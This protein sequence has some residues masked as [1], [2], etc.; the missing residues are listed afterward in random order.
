MIPNIAAERLKPS[1]HPVLFVTLTL[2]S[3]NPL[4][5]YLVPSRAR[6]I[7]ALLI[8]QTYIWL[9]NL[10]EKKKLSLYLQICQKK[11][12]AGQ[13]Y[14]RLRNGVNVGMFSQICLESYKYLH[15]CKW[16]TIA[17]LI[18]VCDANHVMRRHVFLTAHV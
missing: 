17:L 14:S 12:Y 15:F 8:L 16:V 1:L 6:V 18:L 3:F 11:S 5:I 2:A 9:L 13:L 7:T 10:T 4:F